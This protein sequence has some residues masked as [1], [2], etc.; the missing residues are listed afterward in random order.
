LTRLELTGGVQSD[1]LKH[2]RFA[3]NAWKKCVQILMEKD[4]HI[5]HFYIVRFLRMI[6]S[7][8]GSYHVDASVIQKARD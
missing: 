8:I 3:P 5:P 7:E 6:R 4:A 1:F 2:L